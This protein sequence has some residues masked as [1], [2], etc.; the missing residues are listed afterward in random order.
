[1]SLSEALWPDPTTGSVSPKRVV[2]LMGAGAS[3]GC[4]D[5]V[6]SSHGLLMADLNEPLGI[7][8]QRLVVEQYAEDASLTN[9]VN[10]II[11]ER[12]DFEHVV[13]FLDESPSGMHQSF[14]SDLRRIF[15]TVL[16][17]QL[18]KVREESEG[19]PVGLYEVLF[20]MY[21]VEDIPE[22]LG[23]VLTTNYDL[24]IEQALE[25][26]GFGPIDFGFPVRDGAPPSGRSTKLVKLHGS[27]GWTATWPPAV[28]DGDVDDAHPTLW[29]PPGIQKPKQGY[30]F[31]VL[32]GL[33]RE[34]LDCDVLRVVGCRLDANDWDLVSLLFSSL[35]T[36][37]G[38]PPFAVEVI[39]APSQARSIQSRFPYL[40]A[41]SLLEL[42][43]IG[44][45]LVAE[46]TGGRPEDFDALTA[47]QQ[48]AVIAKAGTHRNWFE[49]WL[50]QKG[51]QLSSD[52]R[53]LETPKG[54]VERFLES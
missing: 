18:A 33:A 17:E 42:H 21:N 37:T 41:Q 30:P 45:Q 11:A 6:G 43:R 34:V 46:Y 35:H 39:D 9:L 24:Y 4:A 53:G 20:D 22:I 25:S 28:L 1:M 15:E 26:A 36:R 32:W 40:A 10:T 16:R 50:R 7:R 3:H 14:A 12:V 38:H 44:P 47:S 2:Y 8:M 52:L 5:V 19:D 48:T 29:I 49:V 13:T 27:F 51:E 23:G 54:F 31:A